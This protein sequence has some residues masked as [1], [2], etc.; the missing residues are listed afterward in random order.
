MLKFA[1]AAAIVPVPLVAAP[2]AQAARAD[3]AIDPAQLALAKSVVET[4]FPP[5]QREALITGMINAMMKNIQAGIMQQPVMQETFA[6]QPK[7]KPVFQA[8]IDRQRDLGIADLKQNLP[9]LLDAMAQAYARHFTADQL[10]E[11]K[12]F[13]ATPTG[14]AY[15][16]ESAK[17]MSDPAVAAWPQKVVADSMGRLPAELAKLR[18][19]LAEAGVSTTQ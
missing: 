2:P 18:A 11:M 5:A 13:F 8:F 16:A 3:A 15:V 10:K 9:G 17:I 1:L 7:A 19:D 14:Q 6:K 12:A 4:V